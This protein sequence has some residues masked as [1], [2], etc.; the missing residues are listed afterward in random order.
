[1]A[2]GAHQTNVAFSRCSEL[3]PLT[4]A[5]E[6][7]WKLSE[8]APKSHRICHPYLLSWVCVQNSLWSR[9]LFSKVQEKC[10]VISGNTLTVLKGFGND[11]DVFSLFLSS[12][13]ASG[14][15]RAFREPREP[16]Q[17]HLQSGGTFRSVSQ[18]PCLFCWGHSET[19]LS[20]LLCL[21]FLLF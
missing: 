20:F 17:C 14:S 12:L 9:Y 6:Q 5:V 15:G 10:C 13:R 1:M 2:E 21:F 16:C 4:R 18:Q 8:T 3:S 19:V 11:L 7:R